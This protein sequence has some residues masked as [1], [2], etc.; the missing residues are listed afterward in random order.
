MPCYLVVQTEI[1]DVDTLLKALKE[2]N[3]AW[4]TQV[5]GT[6]VRVRSN[7]AEYAVFARQPNG[8]YT[9]SGP[10]IPGELGRVTQRYA[11]QRTMQSWKA[12]GFRTVSETTAS[13]GTVEMVIE[14]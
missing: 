1:R 14:R 2:V 4:V 12:R 5:E 11:M 3:P 8:T 13:D 6:T 7:G 9:K 10:M